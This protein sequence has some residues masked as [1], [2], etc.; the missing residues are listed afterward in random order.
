MFVS[1]MTI[2]EHQANTCDKNGQDETGGH[3]ISSSENLFLF[4]LRF[5]FEIMSSH[6]IVVLKI[7]RIVFPEVSNYLFIGNVGKM[8]V[9]P[10]VLHMLLSLPV[11]WMKEA[12]I[13]AVEIEGTYTEL[14]TQ[15]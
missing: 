15:G 11:I 1:V 9:I 12:V 3:F 5:F 6:I 8:T 4:R 10:D 13:S 14:V 7:C 2:M